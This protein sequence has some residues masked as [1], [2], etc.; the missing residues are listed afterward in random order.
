MLDLHLEK[1]QDFKD[2][3]D[4]YL[5]EEYPKE[6]ILLNLQQLAERYETQHAAVLRELEKDPEIVRE[7]KAWIAKLRSAFNCFEDARDDVEEAIEDDNLELIEEALLT[8]K[9]GNKL[10]MEV[11]YE[12]EELIERDSFG[13]HM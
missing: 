13:G 10:L 9:D 5:N 12:L 4:G 8:F 3:I 2:Y 7:H 11:H 1:F 6:E